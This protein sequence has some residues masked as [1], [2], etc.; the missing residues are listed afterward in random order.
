M[1]NKPDNMKEEDLERQHYMEVTIKRPDADRDTPST[2]S[3]RYLLKYIEQDSSACACTLSMHTLTT[4][5]RPPRTLPLMPA[6]AARFHRVLR[7]HEG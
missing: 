2:Y 1:E 3:S 7:V 6:G 5:S 4:Y